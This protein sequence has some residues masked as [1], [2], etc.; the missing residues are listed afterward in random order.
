MK[1]VH[2][3]FLFLESEPTQNMKTKLNSILLVDDDEP[4]NFINQIVIKRLGCAENVTAVKSGLAALDYLNTQEEKG[5][6]LPNLIFLDINMP[7]MN[8]WEFLEEFKKLPDHQKSKITIVMLTTS[9]NPDDHAKAIS[10]KEV[11]D[12]E[13]KPLTADKMTRIINLYFC[14]KDY[15]ES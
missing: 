1:V 12:F 4:T 6:P 15:M 5:N 10:Y 8:G 2:F 11:A 9:V 13:I 3:I 14:K 7:A